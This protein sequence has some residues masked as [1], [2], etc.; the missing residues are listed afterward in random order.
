MVHDITFPHDGC[1]TF[2]FHHNPTFG[3]YETY[4]MQQW[5]WYIMDFGAY[6]TGAQVRFRRPLK[7]LRCAS[8]LSRALPF[9]ISE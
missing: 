5:S 8:L 4:M 3:I 2:T 1:Y 9:A 7:F 6:A